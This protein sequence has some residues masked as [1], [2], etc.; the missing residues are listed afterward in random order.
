[1]AVWPGQIE[2]V[3]FSIPLICFSLPLLGFW[4]LML[5]MWS[6]NDLANL[7]KPTTK[8]SWWGISSAGVM[9]VTLGLLW[10]HI[11][12]R[13]AF[14]CCYADLQEMAAD[15]PV[16]QREWAIGRQV[17]PYRVDRY[18]ADQRG[19]VFFR[20]GTGQDGIGPDEM[21]YGFAYQPNGQGSPF[22]NASYRLRHLF[23]N[24]YAFAASNDW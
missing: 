17:G 13:I 9:S 2:G 24:W 16:V 19:G 18:G 22:G 7:S 1:M 10:L 12:Q 3:A 6:L 8:P 23:G 4:F 5:A 21:S 14:A 15:A 20:T 11:P